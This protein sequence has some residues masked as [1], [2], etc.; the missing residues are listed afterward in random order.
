M[1]WLN[2]LINFYS[3]ICIYS[4]LSGDF[5][6]ISAS[7]P[8]CTANSQGALSLQI[9][10]EGISIY[11]KEILLKHTTSG[12]CVWDESG[13]KTYIEITKAPFEVSQSERLKPLEDQEFCISFKEETVEHVRCHTLETYDS[14]ALRNHLETYEKIETT[15]AIL[16]I[17]DFQL[18]PQLHIP[19]FCIHIS[20]YITS[21]RN[22]QT[23]ECCSKCR[24][25]SIDVDQNEG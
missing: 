24:F 8:E 11:T 4:A 25:S 12:L 10:S 7:L 16:L 5:V 18:N 14:Q 23:L 21:A 15:I 2:Q 22:K 17:T 3:V 9:L 1:H 19:D 13:T 6:Y 20:V